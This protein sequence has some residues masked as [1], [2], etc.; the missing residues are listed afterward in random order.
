VC[1]ADILEV[2]AVEKHNYARSDDLASTQKAHA[3]EYELGHREY[4]SAVPSI[5]CK[6]LMPIQSHFILSDRCIPFHQFKLSHRLHDPH[7]VPLIPTTP[8]F[9]KTVGS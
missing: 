8:S 6:T 5:F 7:S 3:V 2:V 9:A 1:V 4:G